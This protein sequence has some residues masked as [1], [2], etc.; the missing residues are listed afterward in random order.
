MNAGTTGDTFLR[1]NTEW[2]AK[3]SHW[4]RFSATASLGVIH[5]GNYNK[6]MEILQPYFPGATG[7]PNMYTHGGSLYALGLI[8]HGDKDQDVI[9]YLMQQI[10]SPDNNGNDQIVHGACLGLGMVCLASE[11]DENHSNKYF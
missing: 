3:A 11:N 5:K 1:N 10:K 6:A 7:S 8:H 2:V 4:S 9:N